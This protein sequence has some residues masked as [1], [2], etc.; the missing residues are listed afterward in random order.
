MN[1]S[2]MSV[3]EHAIA[4]GISQL[5]LRRWRDLIA[6][7][8]LVIDWRAQL[9]V[10]ARPQIS[11]SASSAAN[12]DAAG[13]DLTEALTGDGR[14]AS[15]RSFSDEEKRMI[16]LKPE[17]TGATAAEVCRRHNIASCMLFRWRIQ[18]GYRRKPAVTLATVTT[19]GMQTGGKVSESGEKALNN[20]WSLSI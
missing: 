9:H 7:E 19:D 16:V 3:R 11:T 8:E 2:G 17:V 12:G 20:K 10:S 14:S 5:S 15:R 18:L 13:C 6:D 1:W 4:L